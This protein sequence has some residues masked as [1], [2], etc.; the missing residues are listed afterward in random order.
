MAR[1]VFTKER[2]SL[3]SASSTFY[4]KNT[5][6]VTK[7]AS[8]SSASQSKTDKNPTQIIGT[9][10]ISYNAAIKCILK[11]MYK[12][13]VS[14]LATNAKS[15][16]GSEPLRSTSA[17]AVLKDITK[18]VNPF[19]DGDL[20]DPVD[21]TDWRSYER[22][23][24]DDGGNRTG[25]CRWPAPPPVAGEWRPDILIF[26]EELHK[27]VPLPPGLAPPFLPNDDPNW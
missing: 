27:T 8:S 6:R 25:G 9:T 15:H 19:E 4:D 5:A 1:T 3:I 12:E 24:V 2:H 10:S 13:Y 14:F 26:D 7:G 20:R 22:I 11:L 17:N 16:A 18:D 23:W 21:K